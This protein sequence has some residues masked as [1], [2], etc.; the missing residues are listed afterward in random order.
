[1]IIELGLIFASAHHIRAASQKI[2]NV[3]LWLNFA[4]A[5]HIR[6]ASLKGVS[7]YGFVLPLPQHTTYELHPVTGSLLFALGALPQHTTYELHLDWIRAS[8]ESATFASAHHIRAASAKLHREMD[9]A[10]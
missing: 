7:K 9:A 5:H 6:A 8:A 3:A 2:K 10:L 1:M 4:S